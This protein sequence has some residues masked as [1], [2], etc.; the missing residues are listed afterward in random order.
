MKNNR[1]IKLTFGVAL[2]IFCIGYIAVMVRLEL[3]QARQQSPV[4][5][6]QIELKH[7]TETFAKWIYTFAPELDKTPTDWEAQSAF[8]GSG[9]GVQRLN[10][11]TERLI[12]QGLDMKNLVRVFNPNS[13]MGKG[14]LCGK[15]CGHRD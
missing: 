10:S 15:G 13:D 1:W 4:Y 8:S 7:D 2:L 6:R 12:E 11:I 5:Q 3:V 14:S 9:Y